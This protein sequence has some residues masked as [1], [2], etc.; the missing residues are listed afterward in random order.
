MIDDFPTP[1]I[2]EEHNSERQ[3]ALRIVD[4]VSAKTATCRK[5]IVGH[6][7]RRRLV[8]PRH[9]AMWLIRQ[10]TTLSLVEIG[11]LFSGRDHTSILHGIRR[12]ETEWSKQ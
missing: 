2:I 7:R 8:V 11:Q 5:D 12:Y 6:S 1:P 9:W 10:N 4:R 3:R